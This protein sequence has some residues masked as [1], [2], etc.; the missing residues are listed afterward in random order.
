MIDDAH[1]L[2]F[3]IDLQ[4]I[5]ILP[6]A[7]LEGV[8]VKADIADAMCLPPLGGR[9]PEARLAV[10]PADGAAIVFRQ[11]EAQEGEEAG[12]ELLDFS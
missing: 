11:L 6:V 2:A 3:E 8:V 10:G 12:I 9:D 5:D 1:A 4:R 7:Q